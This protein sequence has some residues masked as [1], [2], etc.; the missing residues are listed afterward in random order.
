MGSTIF[1]DTISNNKGET[2]GA[3][4]IYIAV[5]RTDNGTGYLSVTGNIVLGVRSSDVGLSFDGEQISCPSPPAETRSPVGT[6]SRHDR[7]A[8]L[9]GGR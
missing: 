1:N 9:T 6:V 3:K 8:T 2:G 7:N 5:T 4:Y